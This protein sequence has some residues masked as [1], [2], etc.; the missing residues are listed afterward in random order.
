MARRE[1]DL[2]LTRYHQ[3]Y[4][5][6]DLSVFLTWFGNDLVPCLVIV[7]SYYEG[8]DRVTPCIVL[9][10]DAWIWSTAIGDGAHCARTSYQFCQHLRIAPEPNNCIRI[11]SIIRDHI[12]DILSVPPAPFDTAVVADA[13]RR[14]S[15]GKEHYTEVRDRV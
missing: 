6:G 1:F 10:K 3:R 9:Q 7:P 14:D 5:H 4:Q 2:D 12:G 15:N 8:F 11:T 13:I